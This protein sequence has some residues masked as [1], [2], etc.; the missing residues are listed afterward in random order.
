MVENVAA[1]R[2]LFGH[3]VGLFLL[4]F[5][6]L[7]ERFSYY[8]MRALLVFYMM[9]G[10]LAYN[11]D[12]AYGVYGAYTA[13]VYATPF[14]GGILAD[15]LLGSRI[16]VII[17]GVLMALGHLTMTLENRFAFFGALSLLIVGNGFFK[18]NI[19]TI[20]GSLYPEGSKLRDGG[21]T[22]FYIGINLGAAMSPLLCGY[23]GETYGWHYGFGLATLG[24]L[25]GL[26]TFVMPNL[27][28]QLL[29]AAAA[30]AAAL[31]LF[32]YH[33][34]N[35]IAIGMNVFVG[36]ALLSAAVVAWI[37]LQRGG[38]ERAAGA[39]RNGNASMRSL[40]LVLGGILLAIPL[41]CLL[42][43]GFSILSPD[44]QPVR[45]IQ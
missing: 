26:A 32:V 8:G 4:F 14:I 39:S 27:V 35:L 29:I 6:E 30:V 38:L 10:F 40:M 5:A 43:S 31:A 17:G 41:I 33:P 20:V 23:I 44:A 25:V 37:A 7:W 22:I 24:M 15:K 18:P 3:P 12:T 42:V 9:K 11:D 16:C 45:V 34:N 1:G 19:S 28:S 36:L 2:T 13:L 21:F